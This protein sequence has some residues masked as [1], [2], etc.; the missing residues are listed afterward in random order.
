[1]AA[2]ILPCPAAGAFDHWTA[3]KKFE[4][5]GADGSSFEQPSD[6]AVFGSRIYILDSLNNRL[7]WF[8]GQGKQLGCS[9]GTPEVPLTGSLG[10]AQDNR[11]RFF[12]ADGS[13]GKILVQSGSGKP[14]VFATILKQGREKQPDPTGI[15]FYND[16]LY[17]ADNENHVVRI[18]GPDG[19]V[20]GSWGGAG[21]GP[22]LFKYPFRVAVD[23]R[24]RVGV[25]DVL[26]CRVQ[27]FTP[28]G[29]FLSAFGGPGVVSGTL[30]R[31]GGFDIDGEGNVFV[32]DNYFGTIQ[33]F[34]ITGKL[35]AILYDR[36]GKIIALRNPVAL[37]VVGGSLYTV[38]MSANRVSVF[39][40]GR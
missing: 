23:P 10:L 11:G 31:P 40:L 6:L 15:L 7:C 39:S 1:M 33:V 21:E 36:T 4:I 9:Y 24:G 8:D 30:F 3:E 32:A 14:A 26:N 34:D 2:T 37:K 12:V 22:G 20:E 18:L 28:K 19:K 38:E 25:T 16:R 13:R 27:F 29:E 17:V 5:G 35:T